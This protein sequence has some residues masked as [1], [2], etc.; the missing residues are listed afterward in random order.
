MT[1][2]DMIVAYEAGEHPFEDSDDTPAYQ[3]RR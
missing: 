3:I 1:I 2:A